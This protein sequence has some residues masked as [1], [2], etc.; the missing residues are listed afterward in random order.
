[1][2]IKGIARGFILSLMIITAILV[3]AA[4]LAYF[5]IIDERAA[6]VVVFC[7][8]VLGVFCGAL[9][10]AKTAESRRLPNALAVGALFC[11]LIVAASV[12]L[13]GSFAL[14]TRAAALLFAAMMSAFLG[15]VFGK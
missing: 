14:H 2:N 12:R 5:N 11:L 1:M 9:G 7:G 8:A 10:A 3:G 15:A 4:A 6:S 13:N